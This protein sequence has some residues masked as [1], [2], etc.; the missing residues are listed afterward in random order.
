MKRSLL[1]CLCLITGAFSA[2]QNQNADAGTL[3]T[4]AQGG[5]HIIFGDLT[6]DE[7]QADNTAPQTYYI[8]LYTED[9]RFI[10]RQAIT[11]H[12][13]YRF[14]NLGAGQYDI[15]VEADNR[16]IGRMSLV[17]SPRDLADTRRDIALEWHANRAPAGVEYYKR[18]PANQTLYTKAQD[19]SRAKDDAQA[20]SLFKQIVAA[21]AK[22]YEAWSELGTAYF[23]Q[24]KYSDSEKAYQSALEQ[25]PDFLLAMLNIG[26]VRMSQKQYEGAIEILDRAV[27]QE[28]KSVEA[29]YLLGESYLQIKKG[30]KAVGYLN[31]A[32]RLDPLG[33]A[34]VHLRLAALYNAAGLKD[35]A[36]AEYEQFLSKKPDYAEKE[37]LQ[38]YIKEN[39]K[40]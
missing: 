23:K 36:A 15:A 22:D 1:L 20:I 13:R 39:K 29:N 38:K 6:I 16:E 3:G 5:S 9:G 32:I 17:V 4:G 8:I 21:D 25:K 10:T 11:N 37:K 27:K 2:G 31:E 19:A 28:P 18:T 35:R 12:G 14:I 24:K 7:S 40:P 33:M 34:E 26:K 30:S